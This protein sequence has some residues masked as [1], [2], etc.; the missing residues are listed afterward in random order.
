MLESQQDCIDALIKWTT[1]VLAWILLLIMRSKV[2]C[3]D[4]YY[5]F[6]QARELWSK[7]STISAQCRDSVS[8]FCS[9]RCLS[10][11]ET[12][13]RTPQVKK[14]KKQQPYFI[15]LTLLCPQYVVSFWSILSLTVYSNILCY[16]YYLK[17]DKRIISKGKQ[18]SVC[19][20]R[21]TCLKTWWKTG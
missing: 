10:I 9:L 21:P 1:P 20:H 11:S 7:S 6:K 5:I 15:Q 2:S 18:F 19:E 8:W 13:N 12:V 4:I 17:G 16:C 3:F 14:T